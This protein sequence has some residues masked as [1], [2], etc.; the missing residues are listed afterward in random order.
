MLLN[1]LFLHELLLNRTKY[2]QIFQMHLLEFLI[3][4]VWKKYDLILILITKFASL[5]FGERNNLSLFLA[6]LLITLTLFNGLCE[7]LNLLNLSDKKFLN[8]ILNGFKP[9]QWVYNLKWE[10]VIISLF[11]WCTYALGIGHVPKYEAFYGYCM[12]I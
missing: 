9:L 10:F 6:L 11:L 2:T 12:N 8:I 5:L 3:H 7:P 1:V 4:T